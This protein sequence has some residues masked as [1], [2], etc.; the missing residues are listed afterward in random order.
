[1][2]AN[3]LVLGPWSGTAGPP[4]SLRRPRSAGPATGMPAQLEVPVVFEGTTVAAIAI[5]SDRDDRLGPGGAAFLA[6]VAD[7]IAP[8]CLVGWDTD[9][10]PWSEVG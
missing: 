8:H 5:D 4:E 2:E 3:E 7:L 6:R 1:M 9:G 10:V